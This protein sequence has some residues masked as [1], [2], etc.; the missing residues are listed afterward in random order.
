MIARLGNGLRHLRQHGIVATL[1]RIRPHLYSSRKFVIIRKRLRDSV[2]S[3][4]LGEIV[5]RRASAADL[6]RLDS[7]DAHGRGSAQ[8]AFV[9]QRHD[10]LFVACHADRIIATRRCS[11][12]IRDPLVARVV[13]LGAGQI[14]VADVFCLPEYRNQAVVR[15]LILFADRELA[16]EHYS[17]ALAAVDADNIPSLRTSLRSGSEAACYVSSLRMLS[18][19]RMRLHTELP[20][21]LQARL[22][23]TG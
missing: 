7:L 13:R 20:E 10:L 14:W 2:V 3:G 4:H 23:S 1:R 22:R 9:E 16:S 12:E 19:E 11:R 6:D 8:R 15:H 17:E 21:R 18:Y 5:F